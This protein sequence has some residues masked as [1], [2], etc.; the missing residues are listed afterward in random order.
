M[1]TVIITGATSGIGA[2]AT[3]AFAADGARV[4]LIGR[5]AARLA[6]L[7]RRLDE[8]H[9]PGVQVTHGGHEGDAAPFAM[10]AAHA[11]AHGG[12]GGNGLHRYWKL[13]SAA[14]YSPSLT[15]RT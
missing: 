5:S 3:R 2:A 6:A 15:A 7:A 14:G 13:C 9:V 10:P 1:K 4:F 11:L 8:A 12:D